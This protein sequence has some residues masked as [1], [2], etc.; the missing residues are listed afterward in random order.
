MKGHVDSS[1]RG[2]G[3]HPWSQSRHHLQ[4]Q[5]IHRLEIVPAWKNLLLHGNRYPEINVRADQDSVKPL[6]RHVQNLETSLTHADGF[7]NH[8]A[9]AVELTL[10]KSIRDY[11]HRICPRNPILLGCKRA[12][13]NWLQPQDA[14]EFSRY[15]LHLSLGGLLRA[16]SRRKHIQVARLA[17]DREHPREDAIV[18]AKLLKFR[19]GEYG[20]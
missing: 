3:R 6:G 9:L 7:A 12:P 14:E 18:G 15:K 2:A 1:F 20:A 8:A 11:S 16:T 13:E 4:P 10:P 5:R 17:L 19:I